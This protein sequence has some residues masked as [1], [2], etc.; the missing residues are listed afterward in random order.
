MSQDGWEGSGSRERVA[1]LG[2]SMLRQRD[3]SI[4]PDLTDLMRTAIHD[5]LCIEVETAMS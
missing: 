5:W 3:K 2:A 1:D 4:V